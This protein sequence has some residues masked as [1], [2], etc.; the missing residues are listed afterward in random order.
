IIV[1]DP[2]GVFPGY[3]YASNGRRQGGYFP[4]VVPHRPAA[5]D[6]ELAI[7]RIGHRKIARDKP[8]VRWIDGGKRAHIAAGGDGLAEGSVRNRRHGHAGQKGCREQQDPGSPPCRQVPRRGQFGWHGRIYSRFQTCER[9]QAPI[10]AH[11]S[12]TPPIYGLIVTAIGKDETPAD[13]LF[14]WGV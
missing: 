2:T 3:D 8:V 14:G 6:G 7:G 1:I 12:A 9:T 10:A 13:T 11:H 5:R 4:L